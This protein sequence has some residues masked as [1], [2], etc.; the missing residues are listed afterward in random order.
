M[1]RQRPKKS[2][3]QLAQERVESQRLAEMVAAAVAKLAPQASAADVASQQL[4]KELFQRQVQAEYQKLNP[5]AILGTGPASVTQLATQRLQRQQQEAAVAAKLAELRGPGPAG[6]TAQEVAADYAQKRLAA[7]QQQR[8]NQQAYERQT[9][10]GAFAPQQGLLARGLSGAGGVL[11]AAAD[12]S[13]FGGLFAKAAPNATAGERFGLS[14]GR[15]Y[16]LSAVGRAAGQV[17][18]AQYQPFVANQA[19][20]DRASLDAIP[21][22]GTLFRGVEGGVDAATGRTRAVRSLN[23]QATLG[24]IQGRTSG[25]IQDAMDT[26]NTARYNAADRADFDKTFRLDRIESAKRETAIE[27]K[28]YEENVRLLPYRQRMTEATR[29]STQSEWE[30]SRA[31]KVYANRLAQ[32]QKLE[33]ELE[34]IKAERAGQGAGDTRFDRL[35]NARVREARFAVRE[36]EA[37]AELDAGRQTAARLAQ[38]EQSAKE[39]V[40]TA[41]AGVRAAGREFAEAD[42][43]IAQQR[44]ADARGE[45]QRLGG[46]GPM[47]RLQGLQAFQAVKQVGIDNVSPEERAAASAFYPK[48]MAALAEKNGQRFY[49]Q[50]SREAPGGADYAD[51]V[52]G[53]TKRADAARSLSDDLAEDD[54]KSSSREMAKVVGKV[55]VELIES[56]RADFRDEVRKLYQAAAGRSLGGQ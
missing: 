40:A 52:A 10:T 39:R 14:L 29:A 56:F 55:M 44:E 47:A 12:A 37:T 2:V 50:F 43:Q 6:P 5:G 30:L 28:L 42:S 3:A 41:R 33:T 26:Y 35:A 18:E 25:R 27:K 24:E 53:A 48:E 45:A 36:R 7:E 46:A 16:A 15:A 34:G 31:S 51:T 23:E 11:G 32:N 1:A 22:A 4:Q 8:L 21:L 49:G 9:G 54:I 20:K 38:E 17:A 13:G 19:L